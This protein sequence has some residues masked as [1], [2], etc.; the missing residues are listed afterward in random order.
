MRLHKSFTVYTFTYRAFRPI[1]SK[2]PRPRVAL[3][4]YPA[5][6]VHVSRPRLL[7]E[8]RRAS[9]NRVLRKVAADPSCA[10]QNARNDEHGPCRAATSSSSV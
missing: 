9:E 1:A 10:V 2:A 6:T 5:A 8:R 3:I 4:N 7:K